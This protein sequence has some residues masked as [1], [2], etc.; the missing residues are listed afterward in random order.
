MKKFTSLI[1]LLVWLSVIGIGYAVTGD[2]VL[3]PLTIDQIEATDLSGSDGTLITGTAGTNTYAAVWNA[4]GDLVDGPGVPAVI[5][6]SNIASTAIPVSLI[7]DTALTDSLGSEALPWLKLWLGSELTFE[8][9]TDNEFQTTFSITDPT[10]DRT[11]T[12]P[13]SDQTI[14]HATSAAAD[15][16]D[17]ITEIAAALKTGS[18]TK[19]V[20]GTA[21][22][23]GNF[24]QW[25]ADGD[26]VDGGEPGNPGSFGAGSAVTAAD[27][28]VASAGAN[29]LIIDGEGGVA[30]DITE[31]STVAEGDIIVVRA[32]DNDTTI[33]MKDG[34]YL[35]LQ[36]DFVMDNAE[37][38]MTLICTTLGANAVFM[39]LSRANNGA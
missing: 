7:S 10:V 16:I 20:T 2:P 12:V 9:A 23:S 25:N 37:D 15:A 27:G 13:D 39:E 28:V 19:L 21:G 11:I 38:S 14:G 35:K 34:A 4:D 3:E 8:G 22:A 26:L 29:Y 31:I 1:V 24:A 36:A 30:D 32:V 6:L 17:A 18:D 33:T 5:N